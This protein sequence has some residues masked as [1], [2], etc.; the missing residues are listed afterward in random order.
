MIGNAV[1]AAIAFLA[2]VAVSALNYLLSKRVLQRA[3]EKYASMTVARQMIQVL[4]L[5]AV[6]FVGER[7]SVSVIWLL[8]G[9]ALGVTVPSFYFT[10]R[11]VR[12]NDQRTD[13]RAANNANNDKIGKEEE[14]G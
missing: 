7:I 13:A 5:V 9:A 12:I 3:P 11:L 10:M 4:Y 2:G 8:V 6:F 1:G 14:N